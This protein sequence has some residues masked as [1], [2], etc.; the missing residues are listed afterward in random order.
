MGLGP[1]IITVQSG[2]QQR[3]WPLGVYKR[4]T[5]SQA[6]HPAAVM[7]SPSL[8]ILWPPIAHPHICG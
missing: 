1:R 4:L 5:V 3:C 7:L 2:R 8:S 6:D